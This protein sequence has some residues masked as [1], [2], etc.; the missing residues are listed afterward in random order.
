MPL[1]HSL[2]VRMLITYHSNEREDTLDHFIGFSVRL[3]RVSGDDAHQIVEE[4]VS[5]SRGKCGKGTQDHVEGT[6]DIR[7][8]GWAGK[9]GREGGRERERE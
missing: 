9:G 6:E 5:S 4:E 1:P 7:L 3:V 8:G 2:L